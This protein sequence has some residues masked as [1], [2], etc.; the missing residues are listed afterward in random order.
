MSS[1]LIAEN[2]NK[3]ID[4]LILQQYPIPDCGLKRLK[5]EHD[6]TEIKK[7]IAEGLTPNNGIKLQ[8]NIQ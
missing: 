3:R 7:L 6:V 2:I 5:R 1:R 8:I 4:L